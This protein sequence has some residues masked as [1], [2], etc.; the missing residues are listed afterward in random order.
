MAKYDKFGFDKYGYNK[1]GFDRMGYNREGFDKQGF[2]RNGLNKQGINKLT[3]RDKDGYDSE[4]FDEAGFDREGFNK[5]GYNRTGY[6]REGFDRTGYNKDGFDR[7]GY[8]AAG[9]DREG[10]NRNGFDRT[11]YDREGYDLSGFNKKGFNRD[12]FDRHGYDRSGF[13]RDGYN[14]DG[15]NREGYDK[16]GYD[17]KGFDRDGYDRNG[18]NRSGFNVAGYDKDGYDRNGF[19]SSGYDKNGYDIYGYDKGG[20]NAKG[21]NKDGYNRD[22][23]DAYGFDRDGNNK[24]G[25][26]VNGFSESG[27]NILGYDVS[28]FDS[29]GV[30]IEGFTKDS[31]D[32]EGFHIYS[33]Y[34][35]KGFDRDGYNINGVDKE[36]FDR[37]GYHLITGLSRTGFDRNGFNAAGFNKDGYNRFGYNLQGYDR[38]GFDRDGFNQEG[39]DQRGYDHEGYDKRGYDVNGYDRSG[40]LDPE[41]KKEFSRDIDQEQDRLEATFH[42]KCE[43]QIT[44]YYKNQVEKEEREDNQPIVRT[45]VD[46]WGFIQSLVKYPDEEGLRNRVKNRVEKVLREP[47]FCHVDYSLNPELYIGK[48]AVHGWITDWA[49]ERASLYYQYQMYIGNKET[50]LNFVRDISIRRR[51]YEGYKDL[52]N[53]VQVKAGYANVADKHLAQII[54]ANQKNKKIHDIIESIQENQYTII[55]SDKEKPSVVL[56]CAGSGKTMILM[57]KIRYMKYNYRDLKMDQV[58]VISPTDILGKES[59]ELSSLL[60]ISQAKQ[61]TTSSFYENAAYALIRKL[62]IPFEQFHVSDDQSAG[63][64][65]SSDKIQERKKII[66][67]NLRD[68]IEEGD[69]YERHREILNEQIEKHI[70][71]SG[72][73]SKKVTENYGLYRD[74]VDQIQKTGK[75][76]VERLIRQIRNVTGNRESL[77]E[78]REFV[79]FLFASDLFES[80]NSTSSNHQSSTALLR[81]FTNTKSALERMN[82][83]EFL[84]TR[85]LKPDMK[86]NTMVEAVQIAQ[87][88]M[89]DKLDIREVRSLLFELI[90]ISKEKAKQFLDY[91]DKSIERFEKLERKQEILQYLLDNDMFPSRVINNNNLHIDTAF[92]KLVKLF[93]NTE[94][95][96]EKIG[97]TPFQ[98]FSEYN[99]LQNRRQRFREQKKDPYGKHYLFYAILDNLNVQS[100]YR[101]DIYL[102][103]T[104]AFVLTYVLLEYSGPVST[105]KMYVYIDEFQDFSPLELEMIHR[106][107]P[108]SIFNL[109]GDIS[110]CISQKGIHRESQIPSFIS[111]NK[112]YIINENYRNARQITNYVN[113]TFKMNMFAVGLDGIQKTKRTLPVI[114]ISEDDRVAIIIPD[115]TSSINLKGIENNT[116]FFSISREVVRGKY[117]VIPVAFTKGLEFEKVIVIRKGMTLNEFYVACTRAISELY[118]VDEACF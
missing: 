8:N 2:N 75:K 49:D 109:F 107:Y 13:N 24:N 33:G 37:E 27:I 117:N 34:N 112:P 82:F 15:Y 92:D 72:I 91:A 39:Y 62:D 46:R 14:A 6:D 63:D 88:F 81:S 115:K 20:F 89:D 111:G 57:H 71:L 59:R 118:V 73:E 84:R 66:D 18:F 10:Y 43:Y 19:D 104:E 3:G 11:G 26:D 99:K 58:M 68:I 22:G 101:D 60:Q 7:S 114:N 23:L 108:S 42:K 69:Y 25:F 103:Q 48:Q 52:Y 21:I 55:T 17:R 74:S 16:N 38:F 80:I 79:S 56:G 61:Y 102:S 98:Y 85:Q 94:E 1:D 41:I 90:G 40:I 86:A 50:G 65:Y 53:R 83:S 64:Y 4:G 93:D 32:D 35:L 116:N 9:Y 31:F 67:L 87:L 51:K 96:L 36:G 5:E 110:Q 100:D 12:G 95:Q 44:H 106:L 28:G 54:Q 105:Q 70:T 30:S 78:L 113:A 76:D 47:Y 45:Y 97:Y 77:E 29:E